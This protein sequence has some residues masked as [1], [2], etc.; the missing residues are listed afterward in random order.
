MKRIIGEVP[1]APLGAGMMGSRYCW[2]FQFQRY[3]QIECLEKQGCTHIKIGA[4][5][6]K[7]NTALGRAM[8]KSGGACGF[9]RRLLNL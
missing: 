9:E 3:K 6:S 4:Q 7:I 5:I 1:S 2:D 8:I